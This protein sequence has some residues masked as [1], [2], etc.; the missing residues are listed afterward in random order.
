MTTSIDLTGTRRRSD[1]NPDDNTAAPANDPGT[2]E[3]A[4]RTAAL[5]RYESFVSSGIPDPAAPDPCAAPAG[6]SGAEA[7]PNAALFL[8]EGSD[9]TAID[10]HDVRQGRLGDCYV[11]ATL[12]GLARS[13]EGR[14]LI[15]SAITENRSDSGAVVSY[16]VT[17]H[18]PHSHA[19]GL[20]L[21]QTTF[22][23][24]KLTVSAAYVTGHARP[25]TDGALSEVWPL[26]MEGAY[27]AYA[28]AR[29]LCAGIASRPMQVITGREAEHIELRWY[30]G[31]SADRLAS[32]LATGKIVTFGTKNDQSKLDGSAAAHHLVFGHEYLVTGTQT[33][34]GK[35]CV[36][37]HNPW[38]EGEPDPVPFDE[39]KRWFASVD[40]GSVR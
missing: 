37:L 35:L 39:L 14:A 27:A 21:G 13:A 38:D 4:E 7:V 30:R 23:D 5:E 19:L 24:V 16:T 2:T 29:A 11:L 32:D 6:P 33:I 8:R 36:T 10:M 40:V 26:V 31:Y 12:A 28:G 34:D 17:L 22:S 15:Q 18:E 20:G 9:A 25:R 3:R 1:W